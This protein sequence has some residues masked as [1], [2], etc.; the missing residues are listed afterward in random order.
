MLSQSRLKSHKKE[1]QKQL[2]QKLQREH[3]LQDTVSFL[4]QAGEIPPGQRHKYVQFVMDLAANDREVTATYTSSRQWTA[5]LLQLRKKH[6]VHPRKAQL[7]TVYQQLLD[8]ETITD[9][10]LN[11]EQYLVMKPSRSLSGVLVIAVVMSPYPVYCDTAT[12]RVKQQRFSCAHNCYYC[13]DEPG[14]PRSYLSSEA[15]VARVC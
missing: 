3:S 2:K 7:K 5:R 8:D 9:P 14:M 4:D 6:K 15:A 12:G 13:P 10:N 11:L 1:T